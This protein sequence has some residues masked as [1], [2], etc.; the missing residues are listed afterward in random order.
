MSVSVLLT[1]SLIRFDRTTPG[2]EIHRRCCARVGLRAI[3][4]EE[5]LRSGRKADIQGADLNEVEVSLVK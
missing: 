2:R 3:M 5:A 1:G 4:E